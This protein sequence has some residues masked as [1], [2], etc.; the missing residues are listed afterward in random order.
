MALLR[1]LQALGK[2]FKFTKENITQS[3]LA[4]FEETNW[5]GSYNCHK[6]HSFARKLAVKAKMAGHSH[7]AQL[8]MNLWYFA[9]PIT[10]R[11]D[12]SILGNAVSLIH[13]NLRQQAYW[14]Q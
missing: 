8:L 13:R 7:A 11:K 1:I 9:T 2:G 4:I 6:L 14:R 5:H 3:T 10:W 12:S